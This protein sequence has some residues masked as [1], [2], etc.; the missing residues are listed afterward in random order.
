[1]KLP[2]KTA[3]AFTSYCRGKRDRW[4]RLTDLGIVLIYEVMDGCHALLGFY[5]PKYEVDRFDML[6]INIELTKSIEFQHISNSLE[7]WAEWHREAFVDQAQ[8]RA[9]VEIAVMP[10][11]LNLPFHQ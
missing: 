8:M 9:R 2:K 6:D 5:V 3:L 4:L 1:M 7:Y 11:S 10:N